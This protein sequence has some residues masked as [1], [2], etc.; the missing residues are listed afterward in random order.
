MVVISAGI[1][2]VSADCL[3]AHER[4]MVVPVKPLAIPLALPQQRH[5]ATRKAAQVLVSRQGQE[6]MAS[7]LPE[8]AF[9]FSATGFGGD[10]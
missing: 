7:A 6:V 8:A 9:G 3:A 1:R 10:V 2:T 5:L 4:T